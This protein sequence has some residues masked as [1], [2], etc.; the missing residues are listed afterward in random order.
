MRNKAKYKKSILSFLDLHAVGAG[1][2]P[3][4]AKK[5]PGSPGL[6]SAVD[7][8]WTQ[9]CRDRNLGRDYRQDN[10]FLF[11]SRPWTKRA[12]PSE[13]PRF[14]LSMIFMVWKT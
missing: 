7:G 13:S 6:D 5:T 3:V 4:A 12:R 11:R 9:E 2:M 8:K 10:T 14:K 1:V